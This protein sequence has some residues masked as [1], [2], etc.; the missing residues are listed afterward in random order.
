MKTYD[1]FRYYLFWEVLQGLTKMYIIKMDLLRRIEK[2]EEIM[3]KKKFIEND[4][5]DESEID[6][7]NPV[8]LHDQKLKLRLELEFETLDEERMDAMDVEEVKLQEKS[9]IKGF[10]S[11]QDESYTSAHIK[12][13]RKIL[14]A[15]KRIRNKRLGLQTTVLGIAKTTLASGIHEDGFGNTS[16]FSEEF[17]APQ[18]SVT[19]QPGIAVNS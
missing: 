10:L 18:I 13:G 8:T 3:M 6:F 7:N 2:A 12:A 19:P 1:S 15:L 16:N 4:A 14:T 9:I 5:G 17:K 11:R